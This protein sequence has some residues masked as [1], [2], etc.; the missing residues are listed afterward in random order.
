MRRAIWIAVSIAS[1][2]AVV[3]WASHQHAP[4]MPANASGASW[5]AASLGVYALALALRG[6]RWHRIMRLARIPHERADA[7]WLML[8]AYMG[9][10]VLP[11][12]G[13][14]V[15]RISLLSS[16]T[17]ARA[18]E[19]VGSVI[20]ERVLD[21]ATL[22]VIF[23]ALTWSGVDGAPT[24][25]IAAYVAAG[26]VV[27][28][29]AG[30]V[31]YLALRRRGRFDAFAG[32]VRPF[33][34]ASKLFAHPSGIPLA[35][36]SGLIWVLEGTTV[37]LVGRSL[38]IHLSLLA[39]LLTNVIASLASAIPAGPAFAGTYD[40]AILLGLGAAKVNGSAATGFLLLVRFIVFVPVTIVGLIVLVA[41]YGG[42]R[43]K[44]GE[45][46]VHLQDQYAENLIRS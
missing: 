28:A 38:G 9:N 23:A 45:K 39:A 44:H 20:A 11:A 15:L 16:R 42:L 12:R 32:R 31:G 10:T 27:L 6:W 26:L 3:W 18:R 19:V 41:R 5:L 17:T 14:E 35:G 25:K 4:K 36:V 43:R 29:A 33:T 30:L 37:M 22:A 46:G 34:H 40:G 13:G 8:V 7:F 24:G 21:V 2:G 1:L